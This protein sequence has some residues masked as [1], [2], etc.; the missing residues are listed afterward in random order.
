[1]TGWGLLN[2]RRHRRFR[3]I[4]FGEVGKREGEDVVVVVVEALV[5]GDGAVV[6][7]PAVLAVAE[8]GPD[9]DVAEGAPFALEADGG[10]GR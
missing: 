9:G 3:K 8:V 5:D 7:L 10:R 4:P 1:M 2:L 6:A